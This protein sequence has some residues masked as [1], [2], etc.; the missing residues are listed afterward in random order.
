MSSPEIPDLPPTARS[1]KG[2]NGME[3]I[4]IINTQAEAAAYRQGAH[5][6]HWQPAGAEPV[7]FV[8]RS[9]QFAPGKAIRGGVPVC[10]PWFANRTGHPNSLPHG[11]VRAAEWTL[12]Q[13]ADNQDGSTT[14]RFQFVDSPA[15]QAQWPHAFRADYQMTV[16]KQLEMVLSIENTG[17]EPLT[18]EAALHTYFQ[19]SDSTDIAI[20]G[21]EDAEYIDKVDGFKRKRLGREP[22]RF[23]AET[24]RV[25]VNTTTTTRL[26]DS[27]LNRAIVVEKSGSNTTVIW[28]PWIAKAKAM[29]D[30]G[31][32]EWSRTACI[33]TANA[34][35]NSI[36]LAPGASHAMSVR[37]YLTS[38]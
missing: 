11:F 3:I 35:E 17:H 27:G 15:T 29:A 5:L 8:S 26:I 18:Y 14:A 19:V 6:T 12:I 7:L 9:S 1:T 31:D 30:F 22:L 28:N 37:I 32:D 10:F 25:F 24:D 2:V 4:E 36:T 23:T 21:L 34:G 33:E 38:L 20:T 13:A 16:G